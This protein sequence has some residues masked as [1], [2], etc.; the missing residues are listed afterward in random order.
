MHFILLK[1]LTVRHISKKQK[2]Q[3]VSYYCLFASFVFIN[4]SSSSHLCL[5]LVNEGV[6]CWRFLRELQIIPFTATK[7]MIYW[8]QNHLITQ[9]IKI[10]LLLTPLFLPNPHSHQSS[11]TAKSSFSCYW[12]LLL[13]YCSNIFTFFAMIYTILK[14]IDD[15]PQSYF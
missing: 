1:Y 3:L 6:A 10:Y 9:L 14:L 12:L 5:I 4:H 8:D 2:F 11:L 13:Y 7:K 15:I